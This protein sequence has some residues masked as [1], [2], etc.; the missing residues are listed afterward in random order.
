L[1]MGHSAYKECMN[2]GVQYANLKIINW[3][4]IYQ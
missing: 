3:G 4:D 2:F 1:Y